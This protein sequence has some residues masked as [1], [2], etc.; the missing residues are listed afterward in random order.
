MF[1]ETVGALKKALKDIP[2]DVGVALPDY[3]IT[4]AEY[5][6]INTIEVCE[7]YYD[8]SRYY[9]ESAVMD[10]DEEEMEEMTKVKVLII[11]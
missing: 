5:D 11:S 7:L 6:E 9:D 4:N 3:A 8:G 2:D 10:Y 1:F